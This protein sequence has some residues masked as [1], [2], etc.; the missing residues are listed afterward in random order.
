VGKVSKAEK[1]KK[2]G[3]GWGENKV[4][5]KKTEIR[6]EKGQTKKVNLRWHRDRKENHI[7]V[8]SIHPRWCTGRCWFTLAGRRWVTLKKVKV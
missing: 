6:A 7:S 5:K 3:V 1:E 2:P 8:P 4:P